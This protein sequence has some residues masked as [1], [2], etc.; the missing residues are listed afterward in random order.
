M[1]FPENGEDE[2]S[3]QRTLSVW[4]KLDEEFEGKWC[5]FMKT[6]MVSNSWYKFLNYIYENL[7]LNISNK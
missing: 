4:G 1:A 2:E 6:T 5:L 7:F 3:H